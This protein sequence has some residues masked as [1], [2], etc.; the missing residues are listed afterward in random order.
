MLA[1]GGNWVFFPLCK[2]ESWNSGG[3]QVTEEASRIGC[4]S[5]S[6]A[7][8]I[9]QSAHV[10]HEQGAWRGTGCCRGEHLA[11]PAQVSAGVPISDLYLLML[12]EK[13]ARHDVG[14]D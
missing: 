4:L 14:R 3:E 1:W 8:L 7:R 2:K 10:P 11:A 5:K 12:N 13:I 9:L 6:G